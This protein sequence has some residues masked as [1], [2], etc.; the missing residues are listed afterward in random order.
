MKKYWTTFRDDI[1]AFPPGWRIG[2]FVLTRGKPNWLKTPFGWKHTSQRVKRI[3][4]VE[5]LPQYHSRFFK[6]LRNRRR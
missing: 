1:R 3:F 5:R 2:E 6:F 4:Y